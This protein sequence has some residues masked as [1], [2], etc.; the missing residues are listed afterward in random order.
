MKKKKKNMTL[1]GD[2]IV[3]KKITKTNPEVRTKRY[4]LKIVRIKR[5]TNENS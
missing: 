2:E 4:R 3:R 5:C 1:M